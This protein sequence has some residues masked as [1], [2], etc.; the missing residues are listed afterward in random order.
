MKTQSAT[1]LKKLD[2]VW[3]TVSDWEKAMKFYKE[4]LG[5]TVLFSDEKMKWAEF[6]TGETKEQQGAKLAIHKTD[7]PQKST[8]QGTVDGGAVAVFLVDD[9]VAAKKALEEKGV[10][11]EGEIKEIP[12]MV[13][14]ADFM[15]PDGN[16]LELVQELCGP[17]CQG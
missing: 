3:Y 8:A 5:L 17:C 16:R 12:Q 13:K 6:T 9:A 7:A 14:I 11:F 1:L 2:L 15:D 4:T 10:K